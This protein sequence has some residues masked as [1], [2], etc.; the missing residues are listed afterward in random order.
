[1]AGTRRE[2]NGKPRQRAPSVRAAVLD[3]ETV[4]INRAIERARLLRRDRRL[5]R[6]RARRAERTPVVLVPSVF[7]TRLIGAGGRPVWGSLGRLYSR[8]GLDAPARPADLLTGFRVLPGLYEYDCFGGLLRFLEDA[9]GYRL[10]EDLH[11]L[12]YDWRTGVAA[13]AAALAGLI[14][15]LRGAGDE[16]V[17]L[18]CMST[19]GMV[20][21]YYLAHGGADVLDQ[22]A[23]VPTGAGA[24]C[25]RRTVFIGTPQRGSFSAV[26]SSNDPFRLAPLGR[27]FM[28]AEIGAL[29]INWDALPH[30]D[31]PLFVDQTGHPVDLDRHDAATWR[32]LGLP[33][34][35]VPGLQ[36]M[37]DRAR[38]LRAALDA[39]GPVDDAFVIGARNWPTAAR[40]LVS[41]GRGRI[42]ACEPQTGDACAAH[43]Y[44]PGDSS[45]GAASLSGLPGLDPHRIWWVR[46]REHIQLV[47][48][49]P[50]HRLV[51]EAL[52]AADRSIPR[53]DLRRTPVALPRSSGRDAVLPP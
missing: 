29:Q 46:S 49:P 24:A 27:R 30:P 9:G 5:L 12:A 10:G 14:A 31:D 45:L 43:C 21:R 18:V 15:R 41:G 6:R 28:P 7:G 2:G 8:P 34:A 51:L 52:L 50:V 33:C 22:P 42:P 38:R 19:G 25:V 20:A 32:R 53:T 16:R 48:S 17:D 13:G 39:A 4:L 1:M 26:S 23:P 44:E 37:L 40:V 35:E 11:V 3:S 47:S 36:G